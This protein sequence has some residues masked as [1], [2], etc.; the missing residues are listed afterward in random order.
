MLERIYLLFEIVSALLILWML[1][2]SKKRPG[3]CTIAY[4]CL[5]LIITSMIAEGWI[6]INYG[7]FGYM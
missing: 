2:G 7:I 4:V 5:E 1:H 6:S 3:I